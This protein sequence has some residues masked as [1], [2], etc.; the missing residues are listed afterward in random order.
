M[1]K[2]GG[3]DLVKAVGIGLAV[4]G[5]FWFLS[6]LQSGRGTSNNSPLVPDAIEDPMDR[7]VEALNDAFGHQWVTRTLNVLQAHI[8]RTMP[9]VAGLV[10]LVHWAEQAYSNHPG[11]VKK[12]FA[13]SYALG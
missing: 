6:Y 10:S 1:A 7:V 11:S 13:Q 9:E 12:H 3:D 8:Q 5:T 4:V 2:S